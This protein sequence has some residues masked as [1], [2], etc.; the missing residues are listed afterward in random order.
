VT[1]VVSFYSQHLYLALRT[2]LL[3]GTWLENKYPGKDRFETVLVEGQ[4]ADH[5]QVVVAIFH[6]MRTPIS[7]LWYAGFVPHWR[8]SRPLK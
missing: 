2:K 7:L 4:S 1:L 8:F 5:V 6:L 3:L